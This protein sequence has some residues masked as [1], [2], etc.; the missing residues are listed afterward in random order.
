M[1]LGYSDAAYANLSDGRTC[2]GY[3]VG[4]SRAAGNQDQAFNV[5][6][7]RCRALRRVV[8][9]TMAAETMQ[10]GDMIDELT[11]VR[12]AWRSM[13]NVEQMVMVARIDCKSVWDHL[14]KS[15]QVT[16]KR[17][18]VELE[19]IKESMRTE[20]L[21]VEWV[22]SAEQLADALTKGMV[23]WKLYAVLSTA[24]IQVS[25]TKLTQS[26]NKFAMHVRDNW[27]DTS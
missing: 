13:L 8:R 17:L 1:V 12:E 3:L 10:L 16:E 2:G 9:S 21:S 19:A 25:N 22:E 11:I 4:I 15:V 5:V 23:A 7:W 20:E 26:R 14:Y 18:L 27:K 24:T 6:S